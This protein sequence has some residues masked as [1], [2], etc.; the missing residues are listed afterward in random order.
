M[1]SAIGNR[2]EMD[3]PFDLEM[4]GNIATMIAGGA[5]WGSVYAALQG[6]ATMTEAHGHPS[7]LYGLLVIEYW[8]GI[9]YELD[10]LGVDAYF[11]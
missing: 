6:A 9:G 2:I 5:T 8:T 10:L 11:P 7:I 3:G 1:P 4:A